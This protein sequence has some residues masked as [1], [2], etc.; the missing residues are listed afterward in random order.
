MYSPYTDG[1]LYVSGVEPGSIVR[2]PIDP[3]LGH[4]FRVP[5]LESV[6]AENGVDGEGFPYA[7]AVL[8]FSGKVL[9]SFTG[10]VVDVTGVP[11]GTVMDDPDDLDP[12]HRF[13]VSELVNPHLEMVEE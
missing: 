13:Y 10:K 11:G 12:E 1:V 6:E 7:K 2:D 4:V 9:S 5:T 3:D 8:G